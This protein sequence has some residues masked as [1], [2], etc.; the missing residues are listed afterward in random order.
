MEKPSKFVYEKRNFCSNRCVTAEFGRAKLSSE[1]KLLHTIDAGIDNAITIDF[2][3]CNG[4]AYDKYF[5]GLSKAILLTSKKQ[6][7]GIYARNEG[8]LPKEWR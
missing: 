1:A 8:A 3:G 7:K 4:R 5:R 2:H 6:V